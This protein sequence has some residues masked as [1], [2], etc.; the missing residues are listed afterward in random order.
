[1]LV[2]CMDIKQAYELIRS[3]EKKSSDVC[4]LMG[5]SYY[6]LT[7]KF[8]SLGLP[9]IKQGSTQGPSVKV[10]SGIIDD[11]NS[12]MKIREIMKKHKTSAFTVRKITEGS[13]L[14]EKRKKNYQARKY[15]VDED[16]F[17]EFGPNQDYFAGFVFADGYVTKNHINLCLSARD[18]CILEAFLKACLSNH[19]IYDKESGHKIIN[20]VSVKS[21]KLSCVTVGSQKMVKDLKQYGLDKNKQDGRFPIHSLSADFWRGVF[22][23]DGSICVSKSATA[24]CGKTVVCSVCSSK[25]ICEAFSTWLTIKGVIHKQ[26]KSK[27]RNLV[28]VHHF[29]ALK[30]MDILYYEGHK[31]SLPRKREKHWKAKKEIK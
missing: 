18:K 8:R 29:Q 13:G 5:M 26:A 3:G 23:A 17:S 10:A 21:K 16:F 11:Y 24:K 7:K 19:H 14:C 2:C 20:G 12:G 31:Y 1:M 25:E 30:M 22:D 4:E 28:N 9:K 27:G 15:D 6:L